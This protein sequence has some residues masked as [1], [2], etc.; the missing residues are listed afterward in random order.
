[1]ARLAVKL[2]LLDEA[3]RLLLVH[4]RDPHTGTVCWY[5]VGGGVEPGESL[6]DA[7][8]REAYEETG[9]PALPPGRQVWRRD[10]T[11]RFDGRVIEVHEEWLLHRLEHF[12]PAPE[13]LTD[14]E[15]RSIL[16]FRWWKALDLA[17]SSETIFPPVLGQLLKGL[18]AEGVP[19]C[20]VDITRREPATAGPDEHRR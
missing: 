11:Y 4:A 8:A 3:D 17:Q 2:L 18:L 12:D 16:G 10:H 1:M 15:T 9:L 14:D 6:Q 13:Q 19:P 7:A 20:P 5:P